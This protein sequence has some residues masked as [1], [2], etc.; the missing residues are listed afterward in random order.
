[1]VSV[2]QWLLL[3][4]VF[5]IGIGTRFQHPSLTE[6]ELFLMFPHRW[7]LCVV[8]VVVVIVLGQTKAVTR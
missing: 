6:T 7:L 8:I 4:C 3:A 5:I 1:M 2:C